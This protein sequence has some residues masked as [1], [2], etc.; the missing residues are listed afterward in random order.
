[1]GKVQKTNKRQIQTVTCFLELSLTDQLIGEGE[2]RACS[3]SS[4]EETPSES[5]TTRYRS[6]DTVSIIGYPNSFRLSWSFR[7]SLHRC[8]CQRIMLCMGPQWSSS[9]LC[10]YSHDVRHLEWTTWAEW[11]YRQ[12]WTNNDRRARGKR[13]YWGLLWQE[14]H[15][16]CC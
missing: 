11:S 6:C 1:M 3:A 9:L 14:T 15:C 5:S 13:D 7:L 16:T 8:G 10:Y 12:K 4:F 2:Y